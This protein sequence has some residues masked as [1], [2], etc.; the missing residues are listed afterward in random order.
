MTDCKCYALFM[1]T[2]WA[3]VLGCRKKGAQQQAEATTQTQIHLIKLLSAGK[4]HVHLYLSG[5]TR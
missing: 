2:C 1:E 5:A 4:K 3:K